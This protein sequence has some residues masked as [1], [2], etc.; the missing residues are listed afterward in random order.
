MVWFI[1][2][3]SSEINKYKV[4]GIYSEALTRDAIVD[5]QAKID[6]VYKACEDA[7]KAQITAALT[8]MEAKQQADDNDPDDVAAVSTVFYAVNA[9]VKAILDRQIPEVRAMI[10]LQLDELIATVQ[11]TD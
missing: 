3:V 10:K 6:Q 2:F 9:K 5:T 4:M 11:W 1:E 7:A 8:A